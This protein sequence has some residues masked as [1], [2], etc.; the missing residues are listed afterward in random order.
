MDGVLNARL[1]SQN[2]LIIVGSV[3]SVSY[4]WII[5]VHGLVTV[6]DGTILPILCAFYSG[7][8]QSTA[9]AYCEQPCGIGVFGP[10]TYQHI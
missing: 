10:R 5:I 8:A 7:Y 9:T 1:R 3:N 4:A 6:L 2:E